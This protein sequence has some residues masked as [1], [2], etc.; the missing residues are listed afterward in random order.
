VERPAINRREGSTLAFSKADAAKLLN[1]SAEDT[2]EG[3]R[4]RAILSVGVQVGFRRAE[5]AALSV[6]DL[7]QNR[8]FDSLRIVRKG[9]RRDALAIHPNVAQCIRSYL[10][11]AGHAGDLDGPLFRPLSHN[12]KC[13]EPRCQASLNGAYDRLRHAVGLL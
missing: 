11:A 5:V 6:E 1:T 8:G 7:H 2:V 13:Q 10:D 12:R 4:D 9:G 3:L